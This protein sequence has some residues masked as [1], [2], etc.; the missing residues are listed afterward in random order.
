MTVPAGQGDATEREDEAAAL[1]LE[2]SV[3]VSERQ[4][5]FTDA[6]VAIAITLLALDLPIPEGSTNHELLR[7]AWDDHNEYIAYA[8][9]FVV[10][11]AHWGAHHAAFKYVRTFGRLVGRLNLLWLFMMVTTPFATRVISGDGAHGVRFGFYALIQ[12][13]SSL[14]LALMVQR[15]SAEGGF[16]EGTDPGIPRRVR[17]RLLGTAGGFLISVPLFFVTTH[18]WV[19]W[20]GISFFNRIIPRFVK[21]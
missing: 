13:L 4:T 17:L 18:A 6:V 14:I 1:E 10:I 8:L 19:V 2:A 20:V 12:G 21:P 7:A 9:S 5:L 11:A 16:R 3:A 15:I